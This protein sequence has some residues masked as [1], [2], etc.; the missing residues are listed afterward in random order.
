MAADLPYMENHVID[1]SL[2]SSPS[3]D[4]VANEL[5]KL[6]AAL[7]SWGCFQLVNHGMSVEYLDKVRNV[8]FEF[9][10]VPQE[11]KEKYARTATEP[12]GYGND[13]ITSNNVPLV[14]QSRLRLTT[15]PFEERQLERWPQTPQSFREKCTK[16][17]KQIATRAVTLKTARANY[18]KLE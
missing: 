1:F 14:W 9:N 10:R 16:T 15:Y 4:V 7:S 8:G 3:P 6:H 13:S 17:K 11:E 18:Q 2:L 12:Q 5:K